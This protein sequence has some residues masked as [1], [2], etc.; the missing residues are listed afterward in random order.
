MYTNYKD[1]SM[2][3][4]SRLKICNEKRD[5]AHQALRV[6]MRMLG[7]WLENGA[8]EWTEDQIDVEL[9]NLE[10]SFEKFCDAHAELVQAV[11]DDKPWEPCFDD[12]AMEDFLMNWTDKVGDLKAKMLARK[13]KN[14]VIIKSPPLPFILDEHM[15]LNEF[16]SIESGQTAREGDEE[17][18]SENQD[19]SELKFA[20]QGKEGSYLT[21]IKRGDSYFCQNCKTSQG[22]KPDRRKRAQTQGIREWSIREHARDAHRL[23]VSWGQVGDEMKS[24]TELPSFSC[25][26][27]AKAFK[28]HQGSRKHEKRCSMKHTTTDVI[29]EVLS[30]RRRYINNTDSASTGEPDIPEHFPT[31]SRQESSPGNSDE[32]ESLTDSEQL[33]SS[34]DPSQLIFESSFDF[35]MG[36]DTDEIQTQIVPASKEKKRCFDLSSL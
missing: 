15:H 3:S 8:F 32:N 26:Y 21:F 11:N 29:E 20:I 27:C 34:Q 23:K 28:S 25:K 22:C 6:K 31:T 17:T 30:K 4:K 18:C 19:E 2:V 12:E 14:P 33:K 24:A 35:V 36:C 1:M 5:K 13:G 16:G 9:G 7:G 10:T